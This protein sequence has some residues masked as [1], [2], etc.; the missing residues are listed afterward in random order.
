MFFGLGKRRPPSPPPVMVTC[1]I[2]GEKIPINSAKKVRDGHLCQSCEYA[3]GDYPGANVDLEKLTVVQC[4]KR[5]NPSFCVRG[6]C[7]SGLPVDTQRDNIDV[8]LYKDKIVFTLGPGTQATVPTNRVLYVT[9]QSKLITS[10]EQIRND[11][12]LNAL[13]GGILAG[14]TGAIIG[15]ASSKKQ[16]Q[17]RTYVS[18]MEIAYRNKAGQTKTIVMASSINIPKNFAC[19][20]KSP[21]RYELFAQQFREWTGKDKVSKPTTIEL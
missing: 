1:A 7:I 10:Y 2:C 21:S 13:F 3:C 16:E 12:G 18:R 19:D 8:A 6:R 4:R 9:A 11:P 14:E 17:I 15:A 20:P 5:Y